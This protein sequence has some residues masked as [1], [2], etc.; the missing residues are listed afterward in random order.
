MRKKNDNGMMMPMQ[1]EEVE[2]IAFL[3]EFF[4]RDRKI[5]MTAITAMK[6]SFSRVIESMPNADPANRQDNS[7][8]V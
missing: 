7:E 6:A 3:G 1:Q 4:K 8:Y 5:T 2:R